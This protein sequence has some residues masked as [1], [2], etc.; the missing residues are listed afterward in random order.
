MLLI[1]FNL[2]WLIA[3]VPAKLGAGCCGGKK[4]DGAPITGAV[5]GEEQ[6]T[7]AVRN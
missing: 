6:V 1:I 7:V 4:D 3:V 5:T 2:A